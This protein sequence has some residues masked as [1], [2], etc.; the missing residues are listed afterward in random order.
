MKEHMA[1]V[2][3]ARQTSQLQGQVKITVTCVPRKQF[4][5]QFLEF[6][7]K[8]ISFFPNK[9]TCFILQIKES[10]APNSVLCLALSSRKLKAKF[11]I[12][13]IQLFL[14]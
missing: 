13:L 1:K 7:G 14:A 10:H 6:N 11:S 8:R 4:H 3:W 2:L 12:Q 5:P 9:P